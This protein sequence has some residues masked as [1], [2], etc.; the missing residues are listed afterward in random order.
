MRSMSLGGSTG[1]IFVIDAIDRAQV[2]ETPSYLADKTADQGGARRHASRLNTRMYEYK[3]GRD[4][5]TA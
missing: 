1:D 3:L 4:P 5:A 2:R